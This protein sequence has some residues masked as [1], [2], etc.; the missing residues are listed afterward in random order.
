[1]SKVGRGVF[2][3]VFL[4]IGL[5]YAAPASAQVDFTGVWNGNTNAEDGPDR[6]GAE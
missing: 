6:T 4:L 2:L 1:M 5:L 3:S